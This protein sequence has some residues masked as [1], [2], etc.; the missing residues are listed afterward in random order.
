LSS[1]SSR[2]RVVAFTS[3]TKIRTTWRNRGTMSV[4]NRPRSYPWTLPAARDAARMNGTQARRIIGMRRRVP[5]RYRSVSPMIAA[6]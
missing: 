2:T 3:V 1:I 5:R 6:A 4:W